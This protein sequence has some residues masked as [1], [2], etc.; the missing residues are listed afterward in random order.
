MSNW[1]DISVPLHS[2]MVHWP[3][4]PSP[5]MERALDM[6][7]GDVC[8]VR[9]L[10]MSAHTGTHMDAPLHFLNHAPS[11]DQMP[12]DATIGRARLIEIEDERV[13]TAAE[14]DRHEI[15]FGER[16]LFK[17]VNSIRCWQSSD[18]RQQFVHVSA[19]AARLLAARQ[20]Q[21]IGIDY[22]SIGAY[23]GDGVETHK[24]LLGAGIWIV[25]GLNL[26]GLSPGE[27]DLVCLPLRILNGDG[28][29]ARAIVRKII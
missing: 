5:Q 11:I 17:T 23:E 7:R 18:F 20:V 15:Q 13:I 3:G 24:I 4:D 8:N 25:E 10:S 14:L 16:I 22:L 12:I 1:I 2:G 27:Y 6:N 9:G 28:A 26:S 21:T 19:G 29:P